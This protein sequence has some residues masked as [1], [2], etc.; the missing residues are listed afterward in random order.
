VFAKTHVRRL[1]FFAGWP[2]SVLP[3]GASALAVTV[4]GEQINHVLARLALA[5]DEVAAHRVGGIYQPSIL[6]R[7]WQFRRAG[8]GF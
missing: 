1:A 4:V 3:L 6:L 5:G 8:G 2:D 7:V